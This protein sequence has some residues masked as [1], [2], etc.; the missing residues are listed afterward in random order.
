MV[1]VGRAE[2]YLVSTDIPII[3]IVYLCGFASLTTFNRLFK[4]YTGLT[5]SSYRSCEQ[6][7]F[8]EKGNI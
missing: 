4:R 1:R 2:K 6:T 5:P 7:R 3:D 8:G